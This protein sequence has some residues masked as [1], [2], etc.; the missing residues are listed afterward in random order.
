MPSIITLPVPSTP[1]ILL[2]HPHKGPGENGPLLLFK[3]AGHSVVPQGAGGTS[4]PEPNETGW[5]LGP[6]AEVLA[7]GHTSPPATK[8]KETIRD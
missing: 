1:Y 7:A 6:F 5:D 8:Y 2:I 3:D 4:H